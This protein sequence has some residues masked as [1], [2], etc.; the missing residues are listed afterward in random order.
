MKAIQKSRM[1]SE[2]FRITPLNLNLAH[3]RMDVATVDA[4]WDK[5]ESVVVKK[6]DIETLIGGYFP[7]GSLFQ[8]PFDR[9]EAIEEHENFTKVLENHAE[10]V[11]DVTDFLLGNH[12]KKSHDRD[13][14]I[15]IAQDSIT[16]SKKKTGLESKVRKSLEFMNDE[17][18]VK[19]IYL[20]PPRYRRS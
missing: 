14:L 1:P 7:L 3:R 16:V 2:Y 17:D 10:N 4:E 19:T 11:W 12:D 20:R 9:G 18:L 15:D 13:E 5:I 6:P 8:G